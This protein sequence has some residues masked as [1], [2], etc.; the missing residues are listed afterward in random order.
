MSR[1][2]RSDARGVG[3]VFRV[4]RSNLPYYLEPPE[5]DGP[6]GAW[7]GTL[8]TDLGLAH[9]PLRGV[10]VAVLFDGVDPIG[11][12]ILDPRHHRVDN[13]AY[14]VVFAAP[15]SVSLVDGLG[16][17][18]KAAAVRRAHD[19]SVAAVVGYLERHVAYVRRST[20]G[21]T[22]SEATGALAAAGFCHHTSRAPDPHLH[23]HLLVA[24]LARGRD[25]TWSALDARALFLHVRDAH[26]LYG[27]HL[28]YELT[29]REGLRF[30][31]RRS[32]VADLV[33]VRES[34]IRLFSRRSVEITEALDDLGSTSDRARRIVADRTRPAVSGDRGWRAHVGEWEV[35]LARAGVRREEI[36]ALGTAR[37]PEM[38]GTPPPVPDR[39]WGSTTVVEAGK[40]AEAFPRPFTRA[41]L[42]AEVARRTV[43]GAPVDAVER[44][45][46]TLLASGSMR[47]RP[48]LHFSGSGSV[49]S[50][51]PRHA[52]EP[53][54][55]TLAI[56]AQAD[57]VLAVIAG[58]RS[59]VP[60]ALDHAVRNGP[61]IWT[62]AAD[63]A[64]LDAVYAGARRAHRDGARVSGLAP[65]DAVAAHLAALSGIA[66][67]TGFGA[68]DRPDLLVV[69]GPRRIPPA[70]L[71]HAVTAVHG[72]G[73]TVLFVE[74]G[75][76]GPPF[77]PSALHR[78][79]APIDR[80]S[81]GSSPPRAIL[82]RT[83]ADL[84]S[85]LRD[86]CDRWR[87][88]GWDPVVVAAEAWAVTDL[89]VTPVLSRRAALDRAAQH[90]RTAAVILG[91]ARV[92]GR[93]GIARFGE[94]RTHVAVEGADGPERTM[95][96]IE[97]SADAFA[98]R[99]AHGRSRELGR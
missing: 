6:S 70:T 19:R 14:D 57:R 93:G 92:V 29:A 51:M 5:P 11:G 47:E 87:A 84:G 74:P 95:S 10:D 46:G 39:G 30:R 76:S 65:T 42:V 31:E 36:D 80:S 21:V 78:D 17:E 85:A 20:G 58:A 67:G 98:R 38:P 32:G 28:R 55:A 44:A 86:A 50:R 43:A 64:S 33:G 97:R 52:P 91:D 12:E 56:A 62:V 77:L 48:P 53:R 24:N 41:E 96:G 16:E 79:G 60:A 69:Y 23:T 75:S 35:R 18:A 81:E 27:S 45:V 4:R 94:H 66:A 59:V 7:F 49:G 73:G 37:V 3:G 13:L 22:R 72:G 89:G 1:R 26:A 99:R 25:G 15:K 71:D 63:P 2:S 88:R 54:W 68:R 82:A 61:G 83:P 90:V 9:A 8:A 40:A 34:T